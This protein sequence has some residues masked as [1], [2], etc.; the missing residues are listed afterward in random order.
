MSFILIVKNKYEYLITYYIVT[1]N[2]ITPDCL[3][4][5]FTYVWIIVFQS[6]FNEKAYQLFRNV[7]SYLD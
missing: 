3:A 4:L 7:T 5:V 2:K 6:H 1:I